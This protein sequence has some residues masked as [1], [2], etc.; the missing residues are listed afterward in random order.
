MKIYR[1]KVNGKVF[2]V[3]LESVTEKSEE[4]QT[5]KVQPQT[6][7]VS[8][9]KLKAPMQGTI[10]KVNVG[11]EQYVKKGQSLLVLEAM[12]M[13][14]DIVAPVSGVVKQIMVSK[15]QNVNNQQVLLIIE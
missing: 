4:I 3:E 15:G 14:N 6:E 12:K 10:V 13:E 5:P 8:G 9:T 2:E 1:V 7:N 11:L